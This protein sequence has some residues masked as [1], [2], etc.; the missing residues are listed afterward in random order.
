MAVALAVINQ[1]SIQ[2]PT[3]QARILVGPQLDGSPF[4][5]NA[6]NV[7]HR[8]PWNNDKIVGQKAAF[9]LGDI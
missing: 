9:K 4:M 1:P 2:Q 3:S 7:A 8:K 5:G 6:V